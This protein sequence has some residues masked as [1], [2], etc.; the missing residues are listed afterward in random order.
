MIGLKK[1]FE[2]I[3]TEGF[4]TVTIPITRTQLKKV[5]IDYYNDPYKEM[6]SGYIKMKTVNELGKE[7]SINFNEL[8]IRKQQQIK[9]FN[10]PIEIAD[11]TKYP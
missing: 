4:N 2:E 11:A 9:Q 8:T 7:V 6:K 3:Y 1:D 10:N 5:F